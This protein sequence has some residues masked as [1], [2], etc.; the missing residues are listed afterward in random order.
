MNATA[1]AALPLQAPHR[2]ALEQALA[3]IPG[4]AEPAG[5]VASGSIVRGNHGPSSDLD[6]VV[7]HDQSWRRRIQ[8]RFADTPAELFFNPQAW[9]EHSIHAEAAQGR[10]VM[11]HMLATGVVLHDADGRMAGLVDTARQ[12]LAHGPRLGE[13]ALLLNRYVAATQVEDAVDFGGI[14]TADA[15]QAVASAV[16]AVA[17][18]AYLR[19]NL[20]L[21]RPKQRLA[22]LADIEPHAARLLA[23]AMA[24]APADALPPL[25]QAAA[26][27]L[28]T[29]GFFEWDSG[30]DDKPPPDRL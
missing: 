23:Q 24:R 17:Q 11:A 12:V 15:R 20:H 4:I 3:W 19:R 7:L 30:P 6:I 27:V 13:Q 22:L 26:L 5:V 29:T 10:P 21:P 18:H 8:R 14:D 1:L 28:G 25:T 16:Q 2:R 9:L